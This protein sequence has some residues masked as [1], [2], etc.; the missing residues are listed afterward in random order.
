M[1]LESTQHSQ[2]SFVTLTYNDENLP[3]E[4]KPKDLQDWL[5][6]I[7]ADIAPMRVR[8]FAVGEYGTSSGRPHYHLAFFGYPHCDWGATRL[9]RKRCCTW[10][11]RLSDTWGRGGVYS[12]PLAPESMQYVAGY[13]TKKMTA[14]DDPRLEGRHPEFSRQSRNPGIGYNM[15]SNIA[16]TLKDF[17]LDYTQDDVPVALRHGKSIL[18]LGRYMRNKI[19]K[20]LGREEKSTQA[21]MDKYNTQM[22]LLQ[23]EAINSGKTVKETLQEKTSHKI[24]SMLYKQKLKPKKD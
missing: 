10:C 4:L 6:R 1:M 20:E 19:R 15:V 16:N 17:N 24:G 7:R 8:F 12:G 18:P 13:V 14:R 22:H 5:K 11:D 21:S 23:I 3:D 9:N 2:S